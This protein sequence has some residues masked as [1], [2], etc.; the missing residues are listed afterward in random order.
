MHLFIYFGWQIKK[1]STSLMHTCLWAKA[2]SRGPYEI[3]LLHQAQA[4]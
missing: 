3:M 4:S 2:Q 1:K